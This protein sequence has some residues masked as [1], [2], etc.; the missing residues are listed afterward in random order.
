MSVTGMK[1]KA[2]P[3]VE[4]ADVKALLFQR[5]REL[6][7]LNHRVANSRQ[8]GIRLSQAAKEEIRRTAGGCPQNG[9]L[10]ARWPSLGSTG[11][12]MLIAPHRRLI[13]KSS[14]TSFCPHISQ[15]TGRGCAVDADPIVVSGEVAQNLAIVINEFAM[16][17]S[18]HAD[19]Y[20]EGG[21]LKIQCRRDRDHLRLVVADGGKGLRW[22]FRPRWLTRARHDGSFARSFISS[23]ERFAPRMPTAR[24][25][26]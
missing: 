14:F 23:A 4:L 11:T 10:C 15:S 26:H 5:E 21:E 3:A 20:R 17:A 1:F 6:R 18:K 12:C 16:N 19:H 13:S 9:R 25:S 2:D 8:F 22:R 24:G 7:E